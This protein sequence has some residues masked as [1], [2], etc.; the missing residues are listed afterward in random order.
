MNE[1]QRARFGWITLYEEVKDAGLVCRRCGISRPTLRKWL[2]R[3]QEHGIEGLC[4]QSRR[5]HSSPSQKVCKE[6]ELLILAMRKKRHLGA[7]RISSELFRL[8][9]IKLSP[10]T[11]QKVLNRN[12]QGHLPNRLKRRKHPKRYP[13]HSR[14]QSAN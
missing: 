1:K 9:E 10:P 4:D 6:S 12:G 8:H 2:Q 7:K 13:P 14:R 3:Y 5:P 11:V